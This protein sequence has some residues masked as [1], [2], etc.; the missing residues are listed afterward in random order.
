MPFSFI[1]YSSALS[2]LAVIF[3]KSAGNK[4][5]GYLPLHSSPCGSFVPDWNRI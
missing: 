5:L 4:I 2:S 1:I 3:T